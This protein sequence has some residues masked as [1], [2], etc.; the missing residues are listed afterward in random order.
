MYTY[1]EPHNNT[2]SLFVIIT[3]S[4]PGVI[5]LSILAL[6]ETIFINVI[7]CFLTTESDEQLSEKGEKTQDQEVTPCK[8]NESNMLHRCYI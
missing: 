1:S 4:I 7:Y 6:F 2:S 8:S 5:C 3:I